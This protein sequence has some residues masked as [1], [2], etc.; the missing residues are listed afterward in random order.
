MAAYLNSL[1]SHEK[2]DFS[3]K[4]TI[5][6]SLT[7]EGNAI[8]ADGSHEVKLLKL[9]DQFGKLQ[10]KDVA[11]HLGADGKVGQA[12]AFK[13]GWI[14][15]TPENELKVS[16]KIADVSQVKDQTK[17]QLEKIK[18][19]ELSGISDNCLLYTSRCV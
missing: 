5:F 4:D 8:V 15:K 9:I 11:S 2:I 1:K 18:N 6:Y 14:V 13:N 3:K 12:R 7:K 16:D 19:N 17:E 10:I